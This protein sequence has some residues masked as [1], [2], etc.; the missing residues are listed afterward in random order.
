MKKLL[1]LCIS[2][3]VI[4]TTAIAQS[5]TDK[6]VNK[7]NEG[8]LKAERAKNTLD[9]LK[10]W[11]P[12]KKKKDKDGDSVSVNPKTVADAPKTDASIQI[13][14]KTTQISIAGIDYPALKKLNENVQACEGVQST[15]LK[16]GTT[17]STIEVIHSGT[18]DKLLQLMEATSSDIF[19]SKQLESI[20]E[21]KISIKIK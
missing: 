8:I 17:H 1:F 6:T 4:C 9:K 2:G 10:G 15:K 18:T 14:V 7:V 3:L 20:E 13:N 21:G 5:T 11:L 16:F 19:T 12:K